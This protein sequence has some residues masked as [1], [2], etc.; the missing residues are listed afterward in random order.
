MQTANLHLSPSDYPDV[1][2]YE[3]DL[4]TLANNIKTFVEE[5]NF[6]EEN[7][8]YDP[9]M[10]QHLTRLE[11]AERAIEELTNICAYHVCHLLF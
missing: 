10:D 8:D 2:S 6:L 7:R 1:E 11:R 4:A 5:S 3:K 9:S